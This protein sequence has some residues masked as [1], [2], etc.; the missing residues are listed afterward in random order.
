MKLHV[1]LVYI[2]HRNWLHLIGQKHEG[3]P[4]I[5]M[6]VNISGNHLVQF[7]TSFAMQ[8]SIRMTITLR[9]FFFQ[10]YSMTS[11]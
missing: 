11:Q 6:C 5:R 9:F 8:A 10:A 4:L 1:I 3:L 2:G 7:K